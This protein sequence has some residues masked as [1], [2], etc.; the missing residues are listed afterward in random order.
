MSDLV[1]IKNPDKKNHEKWYEGRNLGDIP[2]PSRLICCGKPNSGKSTLITNFILKAE[3]FYERIF[4]AHP[5]LMACDEDDEE[6]DEIPEYDN[7]DFEP[8]REF[9]KPKF[10]DNGC[11]KQL[12]IVDDISLKNLKKEE[13]ANFNK[14]C[15]FASTHYNLTIIIGVQDSFSQ[16]PVSVLRFCNV[17]NI[18]RYNDLCFVRMLLNRMGVSKKNSDVL[19]NELSQ[20]KEHDFMTLDYTL[21]SPCR[22]RKNLYIKIE[23]IE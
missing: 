2:C 23:G 13:K 16:L 4:I 18:W 12:L 3:P 20:Y 5:S 7:I 22:F 6:T 14:L 15:S 8:I 9:P 10:F 11:K 21:D 19:L 1:L 17:F